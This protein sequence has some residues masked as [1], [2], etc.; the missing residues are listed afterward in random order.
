MSNWPGCHSVWT[1]TWASIC[2]FSPCSEK[3]K[4]AGVIVAPLSLYFYVTCSV[5]KVVGPKPKLL[6]SEPCDWFCH[7]LNGRGRE[8]FVS[9][10]VGGWAGHWTVDREPLSFQEGL[11]GGVVRLAQLGGGESWEMAWQSRDTWKMKPIPE[12]PQWAWSPLNTALHFCAYFGCC[13]AATAPLQH[14]GSLPHYPFPSC[15]W[16]VVCTLLC[17]WK[18]S[19]IFGNAHWEMWA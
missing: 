7:S 9:P 15:V 13:L 16:T 8:E 6:G 4:T 1:W 17:S 3:G 10:P 2:S 11:F 12:S 18:R 19:W 5:Q 14:A